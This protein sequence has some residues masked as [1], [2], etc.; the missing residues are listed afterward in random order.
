MTMKSTLIDLQTEETAF[1]CKLEG[2]KRFTSRMASLGFTPGAPVQLVRKGRSG[3][4]LVTDR[5]AE[6][7]LGR[8]EAE[9]VLVT[10]RKLE[11]E[12]TPER[13]RRADETIVALAGQPNVGKSTVFNALTGMN[14][15]VGNWTGK[16]VELMS[17]VVESPKRAFTL[18]DLPGTYSLTAASEEER[19][20]RDF[21]LTEKVG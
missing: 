12:E 7:A 8:Y 4:V 3:P 13:S 9:G 6:V 11:C 2:G 17:G 5:G 18:V 1:V 21:I 14:Q 19:I 15:H 10:K 16:T 20:T